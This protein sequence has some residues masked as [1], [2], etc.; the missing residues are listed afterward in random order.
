MSTPVRDP[1][2]AVWQ[3]APVWEDAGRW[4]GDW[5]SPHDWSARVAA[6]VGCY[7]LGAEWADELADMVTEVI[8][9]Y[10]RRKIA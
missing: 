7:R 4:L 1:A 8:V 2:H 5:P 3:F 9:G 10:G 6:L